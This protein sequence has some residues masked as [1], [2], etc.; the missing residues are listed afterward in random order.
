MDQL[1]CKRRQSIVLTFRRAIFNLHVL[2]LD[3]SC[4]FQPLAERTQT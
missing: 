3:I 4:L 1:G 2:A